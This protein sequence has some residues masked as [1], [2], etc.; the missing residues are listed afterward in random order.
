[1]K[2]ISYP[3]PLFAPGNS[4]PVRTTDIQP[5]DG[6]WRPG[7]VSDATVLSARPQLVCPDQERCLWFEP[8]AGFDL[9]TNRHQPVCAFQ[10]ADV[11]GRMSD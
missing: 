10:L 3:P 4:D 6:A 7:P 8:S 2:R 5:G 9:C 1:M 11:F